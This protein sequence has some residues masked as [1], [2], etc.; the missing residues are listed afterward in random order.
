MRCDVDG[1]Q[2]VAGRP[3]RARP[4]LTLQPDL[5]AAGESGWNFDLNVLAG[6]QVHARLGALGRVGEG[7]GETRLQILAANSRTEILR[8][9]RG[10][11]AAARRI[12]EHAAQ[13]ILETTAAAKP[14][15]AAAALEPVGTETE[16]F[17]MAAARAA[18]AAA[19]GMG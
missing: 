6:R 17:E 2:H 9:E 10:A 14:A 16:T 1:D 8:L 3:M 19:P 12:A 11:C 7:D 15:S 4:T 13:Q 18:E 5:L